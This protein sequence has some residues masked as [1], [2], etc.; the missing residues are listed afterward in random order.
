[1][2]AGRGALDDVLAARQARRGR[3][4]FPVGER[5]HR[6]TRHGGW[7]LVGVVVLCVAAVRLRLADAPIERDE[8][9]YAYAGQLI[10]DG[11]PPYALVY[12]MKFPGTYY[13]YSVLMA[14]A[15]RTSWGV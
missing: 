6:L 1:M 2:K 5:A 9:E 4:E 13:A 11:V 14:L 3:L 8:G 12:N 15:G 10:L 7:V